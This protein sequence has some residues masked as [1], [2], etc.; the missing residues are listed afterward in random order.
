VRSGAALATVIVPLDRTIQYAPGT[1]AAGASGISRF[2]VQPCGLPRNDRVKHLWLFDG[3]RQA[4]TVFAIAPQTRPL[5][6]I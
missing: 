6:K 3:I 4:I 1:T 2:R 5:R